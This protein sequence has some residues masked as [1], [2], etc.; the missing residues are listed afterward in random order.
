MGINVHFLKRVVSTLF[1]FLMALLFLVS[2]DNEIEGQGDADV[3]PFVF[4]PPPFIIL[5]IPDI[6]SAPEEDTYSIHDDPCVKCEYYFCPPM[7]AMWQMQI[8]LNT[9][10]EPNV[11]VFKGECKELLECNPAQ[12]LLEADIPCVTEE[13]YPGVKDKICNKGQILYTD[14]KTECSAEVC[15]GKGF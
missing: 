1:V 15:D 14:C 6:I 5:P 10:E 9:C 3:S 7:N 2:C 11:V 4:K 12:L 8:C 13:G